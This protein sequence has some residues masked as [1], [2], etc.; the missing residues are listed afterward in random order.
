MRT[1]KTTTLYS[2][3]IETVEPRDVSGVTCTSSRSCDARSAT[4]RRLTAAHSVDLADHMGS[5]V[6]LV[7]AGETV[8]GWPTVVAMEGRVADGARYGASGA[9]L[10][11]KGGRGAGAYTRLR[12]LHVLPGYG[13]VEQAQ[14]WVDA[15]IEKLPTAVT[16]E[17]LTA[18]LPD[19]EATGERL[20]EFGLALE[21]THLG[22]PGCRWYLTDYDVE[23]DIANGFMVM[24]PN[25]HGFISEHGSA[26]G[27]D[28]VRNGWAV[29]PVPQGVTFPSLMET[30]WGQTCTDRELVGV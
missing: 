9:A 23:G 7:I 10:I 3:M 1:P 16:I 18:A 4:I 13:R 2:S 17:T 21:G 28:L 30:V 8:L 15:Q 12:A 20:D 22:V 27:R 24:P 5:N 25:D 11:P 29:V 14:A 6:T 19:V 26:Y